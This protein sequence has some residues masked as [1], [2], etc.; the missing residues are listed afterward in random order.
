MRVSA[1]RPVVPG[2][3]LPPGLELGRSN[4]N[5]DAV[6]HDGRL[7]LATR[8]A[9]THYASA[10]ARLL[11]L[12]SDDEGE[13][14]V[15]D[16]TVAMGRDVREPRLVPWQGRLLLY[17]FSAGTSGTRFQP[18]RIWVSE[19]AVADQGD[20]AP[21]TDPVAVSPP[22][23]VVWRVRPA[24]GRLLMTLYRGAGALFTAH[25]VP[26]TVELWASDDGIAWGPAD[27][28]QP[29]V[30]H[31]GAEAEPIELP[32]GRLLAVVRKEGPEG[33][34]GSDLAVADASAIARWRL[35]H[36]PRK[37]DS[38]L[39]FLSAGV[40]YL[41]A[42]RQVAFGG[43]YDL[44]LRWLPDGLRTKVNLL[45]YVLTPKRTAV[46][47]IDPDAL[48]ATWLGDLPSA[49]DTSFAAEVPTADGHGHLVFNYSSPVRHRWWP[50]VV[51][52]LRPTHIYAVELSDL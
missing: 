40:P 19:R 35:R 22:D 28:A 20:G 50:W 1:P 16:R 14:W 36:D 46:H 10:A 52:Q 9:P 37:F 24:G 30:H 7:W 27:P 2:P 49:G 32:D 51:G 26:L 8:T 47:R 3:G 25:P 13:T 33:G 11:V 21:W 29:V 18:D 23:C 5:L 4:N 38:P 31:G 39:L 41:V 43:R 17:W 44:G 34:W 42:R 15:L 45:A 6:R 48:T 12:V